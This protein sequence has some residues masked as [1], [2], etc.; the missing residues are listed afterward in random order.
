MAEVNEDPKKMKQDKAGQ[1][2]G[3]IMTTPSSQ[4]GTQRNDDKGRDPKRISEP[5]QGGPGGQTSPSTQRPGQEEPRRG[6]GGG[7][8]EDYD[9]AKQPTPKTNV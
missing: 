8:R 3:A 1:S 5:G 6:S 2:E 4:S 7:D 9:P